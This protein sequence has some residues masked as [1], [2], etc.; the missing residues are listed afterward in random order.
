VTEFL[1]GMCECVV[2]VIVCGV[3]EDGVCVHV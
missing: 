3:C 1:W 2:Y